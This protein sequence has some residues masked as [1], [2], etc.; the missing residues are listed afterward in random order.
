MDEVIRLSFNVSRND[1]NHLSQVLGDA[2]CQLHEARR[3]QPDLVQHA[4][5]E[6]ELWLADFATL[7][8][9]KLSEFDEE[10]M[11]TEGGY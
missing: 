10:I 2:S 9:E 6:E 1:W 5:L 7:I 8:D 3:N 4:L 11:R